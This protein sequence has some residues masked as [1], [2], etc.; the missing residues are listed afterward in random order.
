MREHCAD[1]L[2]KKKVMTEN[3]IRLI[4]DSKKIPYTMWWKI[5]ELIE[6]ADTDA[7]RKQLD[8]IQS[9]KYQKEE[10]CNI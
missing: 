3:D 10:G 2:K 5:D 7:A 6:K 4:E 8:L 1:I 9:I